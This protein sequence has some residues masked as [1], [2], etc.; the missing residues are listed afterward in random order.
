[1]LIEVLSANASFPISLSPPSSDQCVRARVRTLAVVVSQM[2][3]V[4][5][6][7]RRKK[8]ADAVA[9][10][11]VAPALLYALIAIPSPYSCFSPF[12]IKMLS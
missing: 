4:E 7:A 12:L 6:L 2:D 1:M 5:K 10:G 8:V 11:S 9:S 3:Q